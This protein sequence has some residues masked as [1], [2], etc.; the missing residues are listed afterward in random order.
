[1]PP[2]IWLGYASLKSS[3]PRISRYLL[4]VSSTFPPSFSFASEKAM[5]CFTVSHGIRRGSWKTIDILGHLPHSLPFS[6]YKTSPPVFSSSPH[7]I[8]KSVVLPQPL[9]PTIVTKLCFST[10]K[11]IPSKT[12]TSLFLSIKIFDKFLIFIPV[13][14]STLPHQ[15]SVGRF[16]EKTIYSAAQCA[17][18]NYAYK[19][20]IYP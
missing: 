18:N 5:F 4:T 6:I 3:K 13:M 10:K 16:Q 17:N 12:G 1:M 14:I 11:S 8:L 20:Y 9:F 15:E 2:D 7:K 19:N